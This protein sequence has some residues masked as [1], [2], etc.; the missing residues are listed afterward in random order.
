MVLLVNLSMAFV[1]A[2]GGLLKAK[3]PKNF[4]KLDPV[5]QVGII[6]CVSLPFF[7]LWYEFG[8]LV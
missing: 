3:S 2:I 1:L 4:V 8:H 7:V 5:I 6:V